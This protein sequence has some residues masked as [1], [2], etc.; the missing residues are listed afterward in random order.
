M[1]A[2][3]IQIY[4]DKSVDQ[5]GLTQRDYIYPFAYP[6][7]NESLTLF[8]ENDLIRKLVPLAEKEKLAICSWKLREK[9]RW[10]IGKPRELT[11]NVLDSDYEVLSFTKNSQRHQML[12]SAYQHHKGFKEAIAKLCDHLGLSIKYEIKNPIYQNHFSAKIEIYRDYVLNFLSPA[13][14][15]IMS[16]PE[17]YKMATIDS[18]YSALSKNGIKPEYLQDKI[19]FPYYPL[20]TFLLERLFSIYCQNKKINVTWL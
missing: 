14:D 15:Y 4:Y 6:Y 19:G 8:F 20:S 7:Y 12:A 11:Q 17:M 18:N 2:R 5:D 9:M 16:D 13:M 3:L 10:Y 1:A